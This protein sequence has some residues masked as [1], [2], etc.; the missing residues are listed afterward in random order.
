MLPSLSRRSNWLPDVMAK[1]DCPRVTG[2]P[3]FSANA[4]ACTPAASI[5]RRRAQP[6]FS[7]RAATERALARAAGNVPRIRARAEGALLLGG[8]AMLTRLTVRSNTG[9]GNLTG[10]QHTV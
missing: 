2:C 1:G 9:R 10:V 7:V 4:K 5:T 3:S 8:E 6:G